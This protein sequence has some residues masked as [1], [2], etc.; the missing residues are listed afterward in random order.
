MRGNG[1][2]AGRRGTDV[3]SE[4]RWARAG[5]QETQ[6]SEGDGMTAENQLYL[7]LKRIAEERGFQLDESAVAGLDIPILG[8]ERLV[9]SMEL[10]AM[11]P[12]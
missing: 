5:T 3:L 8:P 11:V 7:A 1:K 12:K 2:R 9:V 10:L 6:T 4:V